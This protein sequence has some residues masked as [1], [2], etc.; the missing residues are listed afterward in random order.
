MLFAAGEDEINVRQKLN[1]GSQQRFR[2]LLRVFGY[3]L[4]LVYGDIDP[5]LREAEII[6]DF[7]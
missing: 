2:P 6:E 7:F 1:I 3:L 4:K 5:F